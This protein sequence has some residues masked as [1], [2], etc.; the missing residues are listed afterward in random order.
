MDLENIPPDKLL[1]PLED[2]NVINQYQQ[3]LHQLKE[4]HF[5]DE[6]IGEGRGRIPCK[7]CTV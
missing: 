1:N 3:I 4:K 6:E 5:K 2:S 7:L